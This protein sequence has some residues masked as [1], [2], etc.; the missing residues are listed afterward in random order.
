MEVKII[1]MDHKG[2]G[3]GRI[4]NKIIFIP[5]GVIGDLVDVEIIKTHK[6]YDEGRILRIIK[7]SDNRVDSLCPHYN[8]CGGCNISNLCYDEQL[9]YK[10]TKVCNI[11]K[12][13]LGIEINPTIIESDSRYAYRNK[14]TYRCVNGKIGLVSIDNDL[15]NIDNCYLVSDKVNELYRIIVE[16]DLSLINKILI[17]ECD[18]GLILGIYGDFDVK[19]KKVESKCFKFENASFDSL[20]D[21]IRDKCLSIYVNDVCVSEIDFGYINIGDI[22]YRVSLDS[23]FQINTMNIQKMYDVI[24]KYGNFCIND[25]V[26]DLYCGVGSISLYVSKYV[27]SVLGIEIID[28]AI[29]DAK[30]N[31]KLN[32]INN[33][34]FICGDV[35]KLVDDNSNGNKIIVDPPRTGLD[36][37]TIDILNKLDVDRL[38]Y[39]SCDVMTLVRD[40]KKLN[41]YVVKDITLIDMFSQTHHVESVVLLYKK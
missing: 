19:K 18:N 7:P 40:L 17:K 33:V 13:Y 38:I 28:D 29:N 6:R 10:K 2:N 24:V 12:K 36:S 5:K 34:N 14:I 9:K 23:F 1:D 22:K 16:E 39:V 11:F 32:G 21:K 31:A 25:R 15:I 20:I 37:H 27:N 35:S 3:I 8:N 41:K 30:E 26:I 4:N